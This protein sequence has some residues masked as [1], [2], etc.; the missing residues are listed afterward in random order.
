MTSHQLQASDA[1]EVEWDDPATEAGRWTFD[2]EHNHGTLKRFEIEKILSNDEI[3]MGVEAVVVNGRVYGGMPTMPAPPKELRSLHYAEMWDGT[4]RAESIAPTEVTLGRDHAE[5]SDVELAEELTRDIERSSG[6]Q[7]ATMSPMFKMFVQ[8]HPF[9]VFCRAEF[10]DPAGL[11][12]QYRMLQGHETETTNAARGLEQLSEQV[13]AA[14]ALASAIEGGQID[15]ARANPDHA[16][17]FTR[18]DEYLDR[19]GW[20]GALWSDLSTPTWSENPAAPLAMIARYVSD[21]ETRPSVALAAAAADREAAISEAMERLADDEK[22]AALQGFLDEHQPFSRVREGRAHWQLV[23][24]GML[25]RPLMELGRR[26]VAQDLLDAPEDVL[27]LV[28]SEIQALAR[29]EIDGRALVAQHR[30]D[31]EHWSTLKAPDVIGSGEAGPDPLASLMQPAAAERISADGK[32]HSGVPASAGVAYGRAHVVT[33]L[34]DAMQI[35]PGAI[36][37]CR[38]TAPPWTPVFAL[39]SAVVTEGGTVLAHSAIVAREYKIPAVLGI[40]RATSLI[41]DGA[42]ITVDGNRGTVRLD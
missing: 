37:V 27:H 33:E 22:R 36:L 6:G 28:S 17:F 24:S 40:N 29:R 23:L 4:Y 35:E 20:R 21:P 14:P 41:P 10:G 7:R 26:F 3:A 34:G 32:L 5:F 1:F 16:E 11:L 31:F 12:L 18:F 42:M 38:T 39:A 19:Y 25:R 8:S 15:E 13:E 9:S 2:R 30:A